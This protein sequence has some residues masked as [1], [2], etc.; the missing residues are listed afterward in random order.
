MGEEKLMGTVLI[1]E[2]SLAMQRTLRRLFEADSLR[3]E[4]A[5]DGPSGLQ[6]FRDSPPGAV[7]LDLKPVSYTHLDVYKR[8]AENS[9]R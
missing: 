4:V 9:C 2:D 1:V 7:V 3:V 6:S 5:A 8:Q